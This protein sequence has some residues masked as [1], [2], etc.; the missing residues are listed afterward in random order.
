[1]EQWNCGGGG[2][3]TKVLWCGGGGG[4][5]GGENDRNEVYSLCKCEALDLLSV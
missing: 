1:M 5:G 3:E 4:G 2:G